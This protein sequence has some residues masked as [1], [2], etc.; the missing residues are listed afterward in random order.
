MRLRTMTF[1]AAA[2]AVAAMALTTVT[3]GSKDFS[4]DRS[5]STVEFKIRH[6]LTKVTGNFREFDGAIKYDPENPGGSTVEFTAQ[7]A[8]IDTA[9]TKRDEHLRSPDF[10][11]AGKFPQL[12]FKSTSVKKKGEGELEVTGKLTIKDVTKEVTIP[13]EVAGVMASP[14]GGEVA[15]FESNFTIDRTDYGVAW[16]RALEGGGSILGDDVQIHIAVEAL[17]K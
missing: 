10:F 17:A 2:L 13:V 6:L 8:S 3:A 7:A 15:G 1:A 5:H 9:N 11:D 4:V 16:N 14:F 12:S